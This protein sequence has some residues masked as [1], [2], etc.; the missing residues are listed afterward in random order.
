MRFD[1]L[2]GISAS[3]QNGRRV[4]CAWTQSTGSRPLPVRRIVCRGEPAAPINVASMSELSGQA[5][6]AAPLPA[7]VR[8]PFDFSKQMRRLCEDI[9]ARCPCFHHV[10]MSRLLVGVTQSRGGRRHGLLARVTPMRFPNGERRG[11]VGGREY[12]IQRYWVDGIE[13]LYLV[14][15]CLPRFLDQPFDEKLITIFHEL[16]H[17]SPRFDGGLRRR[18]GRCHLHTRSKRAYDREMAGLARDYLQRKPAAELYA[19]L[20]KSFQQLEDAHGMVY[21]LAVPMPRL[22]PV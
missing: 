21:G 15:F 1:P 22:V 12:Q 18:Q 14:T 7:E 5:A 13:I 6:L 11:T 20:R 16:H 3:K 17:I 8:Q 4:H 19:F 9:V 10:D 2:P